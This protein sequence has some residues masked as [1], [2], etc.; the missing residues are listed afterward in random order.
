MVV[1]AIVPS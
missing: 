1:L